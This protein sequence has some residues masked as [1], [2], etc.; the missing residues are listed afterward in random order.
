MEDYICVC[1]STQMQET[2]E[3]L[4]WHAP[5]LESRLLG[6][7]IPASLNCHEVLTSFRQQLGMP[8]FMEIIILLSWAFWLD[9]NDMFNQVDPSLNDY[10]CILQE[11][12]LFEYHAKPSCNLIYLFLS[13]NFKLSTLL[14][15]ILI[16]RYST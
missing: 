8:F 10:R 6:L 15:G 4:F 2:V 9:R 5:L 7:Q 3:H 14:L 12:A 11:F 13:L 16:Y 1:C